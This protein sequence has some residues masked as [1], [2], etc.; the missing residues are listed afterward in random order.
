[1]RIKNFIGLFLALSMSLVFC[2]ENPVLVAVN[3]SRE[4]FEKGNLVDAIVILKEAQGKHPNET[5]ILNSLGSLYVETKQLLSAEEMYNTSIK[6]RDEGDDTIDGFLGLGSVYAVLDEH[7][8]EKEIYKQAMNIVMAR[9]GMAHPKVGDLFH[10]VGDLM[11]RMGDYEEAFKSLRLALQ[12]KSPKSNPMDPNY[13]KLVQSHIEV[14]QVLGRWKDVSIVYQ[15][16]VDRMQE[17]LGKD[18]VDLGLP[19]NQLG[20]YYSNSGDSQKSED[21]YKRS[22]PLIEKKYG[23]ININTSTIFDNLGNLYYSQARYEESNQSFKKSLEIQEQLFG[24]NDPGLVSTINSVGTTYY[25][26]NDLEKAEQTWN[27]SLKLL[28]KKTQVNQEDHHDTLNNLA[29]LYSEQGKLGHSES[30][31]TQLLEIQKSVY[32]D[33]NIILSTTLLNLAGVCEELKKIDKA[34]KLYIEGIRLLKEHGK[35]NTPALANALNNFGVY[36]VGIEKYDQAIL[37]IKEAL[38]MYES[39]FGKDHSLT[40]Q[41]RENLD[42][43]SQ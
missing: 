3:Q 21:S 26:L 28:H 31:F 27:R 18:H 33:D 11:I 19:F 35:K 22:L 38:I 43:A 7:D 41:T 6:L 15:H 2:E 39:L 13:Q 42:I 36:Y 37:H 29:L 16:E 40:I 20:I 8:K 34:E 9:S 17:Q 30:M 5:L 23:K 32:G 10:Q 4:L 25:N 1:M 12:I 24:T 14:L